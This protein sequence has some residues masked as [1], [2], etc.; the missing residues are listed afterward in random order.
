M[1]L[2]KDEIC[3]CTMENALHKLM[4]YEQTGLQPDEVQELKEA[5]EWRKPQWE[6]PPGYVNV[7]AVITGQEGKYKF[8]H[9]LK[10]AYYSWEDHGWYIEDMP[11]FV[12]TIEAWMPLPEVR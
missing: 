9:A 1:I 10:L 3:T 4:E 6:L 2:E 12:G 7:L 8:L 11:D 5:T